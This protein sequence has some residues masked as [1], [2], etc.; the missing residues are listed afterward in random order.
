MFDTSFCDTTATGLNPIRAL[1]PE[2]IRTQFVV[3]NN[4]KCCKRTF[5][6]K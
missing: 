4:N 5:S 2:R 3:K 6:K 1:Y